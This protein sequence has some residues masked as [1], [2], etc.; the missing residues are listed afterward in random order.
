MLNSTYITLLHS[1]K[2]K[3]YQDK[4]TQTDIG[5]SDIQISLFFKTEVEKKLILRKSHT[6]IL[7]RQ[8]INSYG[9]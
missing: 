1:V 9:M 5:V 8:Q 4:L 7:N 3:H 6:G 2:C